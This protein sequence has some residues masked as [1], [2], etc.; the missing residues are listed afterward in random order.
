MGQRMW[1][2]VSV[3]SSCATAICLTSMALGIGPLCL[4]ILRHKL[5]APAVSCALRGHMEGALSLRLHI[6]HS[7]GDKRHFVSVYSEVGCY[8]H[9]LRL[10]QYIKK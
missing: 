1:Q 8:I 10:A 2:N 7:R 9:C 5:C 3:E 4:F 6:Q